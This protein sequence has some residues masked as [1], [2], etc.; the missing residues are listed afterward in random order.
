MW[1]S[2]SSDCVGVCSFEQEVENHRVRLSVE[3]TRA[4]KEGVLES[5]EMQLRDQYHRAELHRMRVTGSS[6]PT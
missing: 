3:S 6:V 2:D 1:E 5:T 4:R